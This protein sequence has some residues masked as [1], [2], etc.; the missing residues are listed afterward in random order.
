MG[1]GALDAGGY[2]LEYSW[3]RD[4]EL[5]GG[6]YKVNEMTVGHLKKAIKTAEDLAE[7]AAFSDDA[8]VWLGWVDLLQDELWSR[9]VVSARYADPTVAKP[10]R[11]AK[12][13]LVCHCGN[14]Y[15]ARIADLKRGYG[16]SCCKR[17]ASV[18]RSYG[19]PDAKTI[20]GKS[21]KQ[22]IKE[23]KC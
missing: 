6:E 20:D 13:D 15:Q 19:R 14:L 10:T 12:L 3:Q 21:I 23:L 22:A 4:S 8:E 5:W 7:C 18:K 11:G 9:P 16:K 17:C 1:Q 2:E